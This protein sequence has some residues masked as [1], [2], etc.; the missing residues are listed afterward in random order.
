MVFEMFKTFFCGR[1]MQ[2]TLKETFKSI[3]DFI[4]RCCAPFIHSFS[5]DLTQQLSSIT[6][7]QHK[8]VRGCS[9]PAGSYWRIPRKSH[10]T[11][12]SQSYGPVE[13]ELPK[14]KGTWESESKGSAPEA[15]NDISKASN[16]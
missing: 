9:S 7:H 14:F 1:V 11:D 12:G 4:P 8:H 10:L 6:W 2:N 16:W 3:Q 5:V 15:G 13:K